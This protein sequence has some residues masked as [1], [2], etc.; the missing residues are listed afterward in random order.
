MAKGSRHIATMT[1]MV[2]AR[3]GIWMV[4]VW[5]ALPALSAEFTEHRIDVGGHHLTARTWGEGEPAVVLDT[6]MGESLETWK[7]LPLEIARTSRVVAYDRAG[8]GESELGPE[9][10]DAM[11]VARD[12]RALLRGLEIPAPYVLVG[13]SLGGLH[14]RAFAELYPEEVA[15]LVFIDPTTE[16]MHESLKTEEGRA[17]VMRQLAGETEGVKA[18]ARGT[19][20]S[21]EQIAEMGAPPDVPAVVLTAMAPIS[22][23]EEYRQQ[24]EAAGMSE[25]RLDALQQR[26]YQLHTHLAAQLPQGDHLVTEKSHHYIHYDEPELVLGEIERLVQQVRTAV[27]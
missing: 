18:E 11:A 23:P 26:K 3:F 2:G 9:P 7:D 27:R 24:A 8:L 4:L 21:L 15:A 1:G 17:D 25:Q 16:G 12:L 19:P 10:R 22:I 6:G 20:A 14:I 13:H 5:G